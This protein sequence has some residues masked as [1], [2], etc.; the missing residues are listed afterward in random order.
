MLAKNKGSTAGCAAL[1]CIRIGKHRAFLSN[2]VDVGRVIAHDAVIVGA[3]VVYA[4]I[5]APKD[6]DVR[7]RAFVLRE[8]GCRG[9]DG[10]KTK[11]SR[12]WVGSFLH[13]FS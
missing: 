4:D 1:L 6:D 7:L 10:D 3:D 8:H 9:S 12:K 11:E 2:P 13:S 5:I